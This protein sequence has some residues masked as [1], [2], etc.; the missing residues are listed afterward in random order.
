MSVIWVISWILVH[1]ARV[2]QSML[3][4]MLYV[5]TPCVILDL[6]ISLLT[7]KRYFLNYY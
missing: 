1:D 5:S 7:D 2:E 3:Y 6:L 4:T